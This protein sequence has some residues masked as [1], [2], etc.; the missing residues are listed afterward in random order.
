MAAFAVSITFRFLY[1]RYHSV[2]ANT[3]HQALLRAIYKVLRPMVRL[4]MRHGV[5]YKTFADVAR[6][7]FVDVAEEDFALPGRK[8]SNARTAVLTG[9]NRKDIAKL[10]ARAHPLSEAG[11]DSPNPAA[12][13]I[14]AWLNDARFQ[15]HA[16]KPKP[17]FVEDQPVQP[18]SFTSLAKDYSSDVPVRALIDELLRIAAIKRDG[19]EVTLLANAY[20]PITDVRENLRI[21]GTAAA[22]LLS[23]MDHNIGR[24]APAPRLQR[25]VS[26]NKVSPEDLETVRRRCREEGEALLLKVNAWLSEYEQDEGSPATDAQTF[27]TGLG[28]YYIEEPS[29]DDSGGSPPQ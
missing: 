1:H 9:V 23:T 11:A 14:T 4:L 3:P 12:R 28:V 26:Y 22:D 8:P 16:G 21:F 7:V 29:P 6:H 24:E 18:D 27:R 2:M 25:T 5:S 15:D 17:L 20:V 19:D 10:K 13:V